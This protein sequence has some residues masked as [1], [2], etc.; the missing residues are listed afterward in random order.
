M[1]RFEE[2]ANCLLPNGVTVQ[3]GKPPT[4]DRARYNYGARLL[5]APRP[6]DAESLWNFLHECA[7]AILHSDRSV[8]ENAPR[9][10]T[11]YECERWTWDRFVEKQI[12]SDEPMKELMK[13]SSGYLKREIM[14]DLED[15]LNR[16]LDQRAIGYLL[17]SDRNDLQNSVDE[18]LRA[19]F[20][21]VV[22]WA[23]IIP[24]LGH[25]TPEVHFRNPACPS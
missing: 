23:T 24:Y 20:A 5:Q 3:Y 19:Q 12:V 17:Q 25:V 6:E 22:T 21:G 2:I 16:G 18:H 1:N 13:E 11:E 9:H 7:H 15:V 10:V 8:F 14:R 4:G